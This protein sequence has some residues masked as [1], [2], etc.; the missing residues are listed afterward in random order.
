MGTSYTSDRCVGTF[1]GNPEDVLTIDP[2]VSYTCSDSRNKCTFSCPNHASANEPESLLCDAQTLQFLTGSRKRVSCSNCP[3][4]GPDSSFTLA[5]GLINMQTACKYVT[6]GDEDIH[7]SIQC[8]LICLNRAIPSVDLSKQL[9]ERVRCVKNV[10]TGAS[11]WMSLIRDQFWPQFGLICDHSVKPPPP[12]K[13]PTLRETY[14]VDVTSVIVK[15]T[16]EMRGFYSLH[17]L[18]R[19]SCFN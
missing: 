18:N 7:L 8:D 5:T 13:C 12:K 15:C 2:G 14:Q 6:K 11:K 17:T 9:L 3:S 10:D 16:W 1:C 4:F 19:K